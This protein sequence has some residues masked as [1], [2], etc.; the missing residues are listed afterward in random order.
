MS[1]IDKFSFST[2]IDYYRA[3]KE[4]QYEE[5]QRAIGIMCIP[6]VKEQKQK[7]I[8][9]RLTCKPAHDIQSY[10]DIAMLAVRSG[11]HVRKIGQ[12]WPGSKEK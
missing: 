10:P 2:A 7:E 3:M 5:A 12:K 6:H 11:Q 8:I 1:E 9:T 4:L